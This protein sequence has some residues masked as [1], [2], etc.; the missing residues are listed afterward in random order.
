MKD[1]IGSSAP[2]KVWIGM[3]TAGT[4]TLPSV[5]RSVVTR[6]LHA[7]MLIAVLHQL[8][9]SNFLSRPLP[10]EAPEVSFLLH[11]YVGMGS[12]AIVS[13]FWIWTLVRRG[14][15]Q[16]WRLVPW[17]SMGGIKSVLADTT[18][19]LGHLIRSKAPDATEGALASAVHGLGLLTLT[20]MAFTGTVYFLIAGTYAG[21]LILSLHELMANLMWGYLIAH[22]GLAIVHQL[23]GS[24]MVSR[25][26][27]RR[28]SVSKI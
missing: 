25:M 3:S 5:N 2:T 21:K 24:D 26:F 13:L 11:E 6:L 17:F 4:A 19:Q 14:E 18:E 23:L 12:M 7:L 15:T 20:A 1:D 27:W 8:I 9:G 16:I 22:A 10:G 28:G